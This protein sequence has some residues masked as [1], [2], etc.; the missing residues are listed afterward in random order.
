[1]AEQRLLKVLDHLQS[2]WWLCWT[3]PEVHVT[4]L[5]PSQLSGDAGVPCARGPRLW[6]VGW[7]ENGERQ[8]PGPRA[9][10]FLEPA[11]HPPSHGPAPGHSSSPSFRHQA[12]L[13]AAGENTA[14]TSPRGQRPAEGR[15]PGGGWWRAGRWVGW[16][17][18]LTPTSGLTLLFP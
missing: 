15:A 7:A 18:L 9:R 5:R 10:G 2:L 6:P 16:Q 17:W 12:M 3:P 1:M 14:L 11:G 4:D 8:A 13:L